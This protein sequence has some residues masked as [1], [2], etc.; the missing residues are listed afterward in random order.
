M[1]SEDVE[2]RWWELNEE[3][4][5]GWRSGGGRTREPP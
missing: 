2:A 1:W 3:V 4:I 5:R